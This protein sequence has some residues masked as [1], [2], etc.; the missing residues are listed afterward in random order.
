MFG[1][2]KISLGDVGKGLLMAILAPSFVALTAVL[3][4]VIQAPGFDVFSVNWHVLGHNL[5]NTEIV[6]SYGAFVGY[7]AKNFFTD[8]QGNLLGINSNK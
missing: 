2:F 7:L 4:V 1:M 3:G 5:I 8:N 6:V